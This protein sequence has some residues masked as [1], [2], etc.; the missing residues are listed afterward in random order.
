M[1]A[2]NV[3]QFE[4]HDATLRIDKWLW[5]CRFFK[6]R[7]HAARF[8]ASGKV[9]VNRRPISNTAHPLKQGDILTFVHQDE[10]QVVLVRA[11]GTRRGPLAEAKCLYQDLSGTQ[12]ILDHDGPLA[13]ASRPMID[14]AYGQPDIIPVRAAHG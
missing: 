13:P 12:N 4:A 5:H 11:L 8:V 9:R 2:S 7:S 1:T 14:P 10:V 3:T 6:S